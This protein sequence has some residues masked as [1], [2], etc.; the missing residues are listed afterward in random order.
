MVLI[1]EL[2]FS[3]RERESLSYLEAKTCL[4]RRRRRLVS[5]DNVAGKT[6]ER[7][8]SCIQT[9]YSNLGSHLTSYTEVLQTY[10]LLLLNTYIK[11]DK[12]KDF[13]KLKFLFIYILCFCN[14]QFLRLSN[15]VLVLKLFF[16]CF[17]RRRKEE[18][19]KKKPTL[20]TNYSFL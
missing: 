8:H 11:R 15:S 17:R 1:T 9:V 4:H 2:R 3:K 6:L 18:M 20:R 16:L 19:D 14:C 10:L 5:P 13:H 7:S 12:L